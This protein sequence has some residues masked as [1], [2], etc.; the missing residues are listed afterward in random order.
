MSKLTDVAPLITD[1]PPDGVISHKNTVTW[2]AEPS[3]SSHLRSKL[4]NAS[5]VEINGNKY[6]RGEGK[7][8]SRT[9]RKA[10]PRKS[11]TCPRGGNV[12]SGDFRKGTRG[13]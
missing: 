3:S 2:K 1:M 10:T 8:G 5:P 9:A 13:Y 7:E 4:S 11:I 6:L 12:K